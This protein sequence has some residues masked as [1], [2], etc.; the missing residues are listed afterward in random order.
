VVE[1]FSLPLCDYLLFKKLYTN[2]IIISN[3]IISYLSN[4]K[5]DLNS[6]FLLKA[7]ALEGRGLL[8]EA[9]SLYEKVC[10]QSEAESLEN[11][12]A[13]TRLGI[14]QVYAGS[15]EVGMLSIQK[16]LI[17]IEKFIDFNPKSQANLKLLELKTDIFNT[18]AYAA[19]NY[20]EFEKSISLYSELLKIIRE[21]KLFHKLVIPLVYQGILYRRIGD[22]H[23]AFFR[24][25]E[26][27]EQARQVN[28]EQAKTW[29]A[30]HLAWV[31]LN[32]GNFILAEDQCIFSLEGYKKIDN[33]G[34][35]ADNYEQLGFIH[36]AQGKINAAIDNFDL[37]FKIRDE[38]GN[39]HG[40]ASCMLGL[41]FSSWQDK[42]YL[43]FMKFLIQGFNQYYKIGVL[44]YSRFFRM[45][46]LAYV[47]T[48]GK[49]KW[50]M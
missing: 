8:K 16:M 6:V 44:N 7:K 34:G 10:F 4:K 5:T 38:M 30:H 36:I 14:N 25:T 40:T 32:Q 2:L 43:D 18:L 12:E 35:I 21:N 48:I 19:M 11:I 29:I 13:T 46:K 37:A 24:L 50:T 26:A 45:L 17:D 22:Y 15:Y 20:C 27:R 41:A 28:D 49:K 23:R 9:Q 47:W 39:R 3:E 42:R 33:R 1:N 31:L